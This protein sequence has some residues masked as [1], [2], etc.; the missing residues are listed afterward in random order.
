L[1]A[2]A[3][4]VALAA[5]AGAA[6]TYWGGA[7]DRRLADRYRQTVAAGRYPQPTP[8]TTAAGSVVGQVFLYQGAPPWVMVALTAAPEP[9]DYTMV[10]V[11]RDGYRYPAGV[12]PVTGRTGTTGYPLPVPVDRIA[13]IELTH[14]GIRLSVHPLPR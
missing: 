10:V 1:V 12:C 14:P 5:G 3:V 11:T 4:A 9:G 2:A 7:A 6:G 8:V 13:S